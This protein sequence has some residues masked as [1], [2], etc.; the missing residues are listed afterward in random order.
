MQRLTLYGREVIA[1]RPR[2]GAGP[3]EI[4]K[5][6]GRDHSL[7]SRELRR[8]MAQ[9]FPYEATSAQRYAERRAGKTKVRKLQ[10]HPKL[11]DWVRGKLH[12]KW[13][14][15]QIAGRLRDQP[16]PELKGLAVSHEAIYRWICAASPRGEPWL[17]RRVRKYYLGVSIISQ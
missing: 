15:E 2:Q 10:K 5:E 13:S 3:R 16:P 11:R 8:N 9:L 14:P 12:K 6:I 4:G 17:V 7:I 1:T